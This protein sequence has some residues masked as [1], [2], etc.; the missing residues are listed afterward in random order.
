MVVQPPE[1]AVQQTRQLL[2]GAMHRLLQR[3]T[4]RTAR[5]LDPAIGERAEGPLFA[6]VNGDR[7]T[8]DAAARIVRQIAKAAGISKRIGPHSLRH[9]FITAAL[10]AGARADN[11]TRTSPQ[12]DT[13]V[14]HCG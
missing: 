13:T 2:R 1:R 14:S 12:T 10:D 8:R 11:P 3:L 9:S 7:M 4:P 5:A 6:G